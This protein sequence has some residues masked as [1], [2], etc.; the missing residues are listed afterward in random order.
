MNGSIPAN[1]KIRRAFLLIEN[2]PSQSKDLTG[3]VLHTT[4]LSVRLFSWGLGTNLTCQTRCQT[5]Q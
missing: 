3:G 4:D 2:L 5:C 1:R